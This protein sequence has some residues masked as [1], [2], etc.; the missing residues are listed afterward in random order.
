MYLMSESIVFITSLLDDPWVAAHNFLAANDLSQLFLDQVVDFI[1]KNTKDV[2]I[3]QAA[4][5][6]SDPL[7]GMYE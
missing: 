3:G 2:T 1:L 4:P 7:T 5:A 6:A